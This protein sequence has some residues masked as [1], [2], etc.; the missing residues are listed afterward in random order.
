MTSSTSDTNG[1]ARIPDVGP[2]TPQV[3]AH[4]SVELAFGGPPPEFGHTCWQYAAL[5]RAGARIRRP[6][7]RNRI[8]TVPNGKPGRIP[9]GRGDS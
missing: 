6:T 8:A 5:T 9:R 3:R 4:D 2:E 1:I 7:A